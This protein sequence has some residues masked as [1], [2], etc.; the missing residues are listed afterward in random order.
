M[1]IV[2]RRTLKMRREMKRLNFSKKR[3]A[4]LKVLCSTKTH[5]TAEW[6]YA[7]LKQE[8]PDFS[9]GT[10]YRNLALFKEQGLVVA[11]A[12]VNG[13]ERYDGVTASHSHF[14]CKRC[15]SVFDVEAPGA[16]FELDSRIAR[17]YGCEVERHNLCFYG[18]CSRCR[19]EEE[20]GEQT[21]DVS[22]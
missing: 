13:Q 8:Y 4:V 17:R 14:V 21:K 16:D 22:V 1:I 6:I 19:Q 20:S 11:V 2:F 15:G 10:V 5:P 9:L 18:T 12:N 7:H 3:D